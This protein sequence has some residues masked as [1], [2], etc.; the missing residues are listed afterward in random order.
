M[1]IE[2]ETHTPEET[3]DAAQKLAKKIKGG[4]IVCLSGEMGAGKTLFAQGFAK[5]LGIKDAVTSPTFTIVNEYT[6]VVT[7][8]YH[9][10]AYRIEDPD[11][12]YEIGFDEYL[13]SGGICLI[14]WPEMIEELIPQSHVS[15]T[16]KRGDNP[17]K[18]RIIIIEGV[19]NE[20]TWN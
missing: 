6:D 9:F 14:E 13:F 16:I 8:F 4:D 18:D 7:P 11:E 5:G 19:E 15:V 1:S 12:M 3:F 10:D 20:G 2:F 17:S